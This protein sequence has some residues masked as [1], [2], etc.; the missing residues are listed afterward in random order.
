MNDTYEQALDYTRENPGKAA[1]V[2]F[3][4][5]IGVGLLLANSTNLTGRSRTR[6]IVPPVMNA[7]S[8]IAAEL[9]R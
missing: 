5:G 9:F 7:L 3:G 6:R 2:M 1:L 8:D 4:V